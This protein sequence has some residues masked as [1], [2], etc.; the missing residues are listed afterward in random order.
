MK[1][2]V[3]T[4]DRFE[5]LIRFNEEVF[6]TWSSAAARFKFHVLANPFLE[7]PKRPDVL[8]VMDDDGNIVGQV[9]LI[10][11]EL[12]SP[13]TARQRCY[14]GTDLFVKESHRGGVTG[15][16]L[17]LK[18]A[19]AYSPFFSVAPSADSLKILSAAGINTIGSLRKLMWLRGRRRIP[20]MVRSLL[21]ANSLKR[22]IVLPP[23]IAAHGERFRRVGAEALGDLVEIPW[24]STALQFG[25]SAVFLRWRFFLVSVLYGIYALQSDPSCFFVVRAA[26]RRGFILIAIV[27]YR[28]AWAQRHQFQA[29]IAAAKGLAVLGK[30]DGVITMTSLEP[31]ERELR[32]ASF[33]GVGTP[34]RIVSTWTGPHDI[35]VTM[36]DCDTDLRFDQAGEEFG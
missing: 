23:E 2:S 1:L 19:R 30:F 10:A 26:H 20:S 11:T 8:I 14:V 24:S 7:S 25:R 18:I 13:G 21:R 31:L 6:P 4:E 17:A 5:D 33:V 28:M 12:L 16:A 34:A 29:M 15:A 36:A 32:A 35:F 22:E 3:L 27:D 9:T